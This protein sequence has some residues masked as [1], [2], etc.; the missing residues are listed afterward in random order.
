[1][2]RPCN[3]EFTCPTCGDS[4]VMPGTVDDDELFPRRCM[5]CAMDG[6]VSYYNAGRV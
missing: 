1:M 6:V 3:W 2:P 4:Y 5:T